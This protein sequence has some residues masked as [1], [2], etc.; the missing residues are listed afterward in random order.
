MAW[1]EVRDVALTA[2]VFLLIASV[3]AFAQEEPAA[4]EPPPIPLHALEGVGG[5]LITHS[6]YLV[7]P[8]K[9][10]EVFGLPSL[11]F[12]YADLGHSRHLTALTLTET[13]G[14]RLELGYAWNR[15]DIGDLAR[16]LGV[17]NSISLHHFNARL[18]L[19]KDGQFDQPWLP[20]ITFGTH[21]KYNQDV[22]D[23]NKDL[24]GL[25]RTAGIKDDRGVDFTLY[26]SKMIPGLP[27][28]VMLNLGVRSTDAAQ[29]GLLGFTRDRVIRPEGNVVVLVTDRMGVS[30]EYRMKPCKYNRI[31]NFV[32][33]EDDWW[34]L[35]AFYVINSHLTVTGVYGHFGQV[36]NHK[37]NEVWALRFKWE[38]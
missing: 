14:D 24:G 31:G 3:T 6:A 10:G 34:T 1:K 26:G 11:G 16:L 33:K 4:S 21:F 18:A 30:G 15:L 35:C 5:V 7:N 9:E 25:L 32:E 12:A 23:I 22:D 20:Q 13:I 36:L 27:R 28:P 37:A 2:M 29:I 19:V 17:H 8:A 38:F